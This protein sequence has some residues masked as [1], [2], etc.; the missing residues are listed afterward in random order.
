MFLSRLVIYNASD[1]INLNCVA[2]LD[3]QV[4]VIFVMTFFIQTICSQLSIYNMIILVNL[5]EVR[6]KPFGVGWLLTIG[7]RH[8]RH[9]HGATF[10]WA[11]SK[12]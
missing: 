4:C 5:P 9:I 3:I 2:S 1:V 6:E 11:Q 7:Q 10:L 12:N 8:R